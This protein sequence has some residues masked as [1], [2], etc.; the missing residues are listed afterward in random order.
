MFDHPGRSGRLE[1]LGP[2]LNPYRRQLGT[3]SEPDAARLVVEAKAVLPPSVRG[4]AERKR[5]QLER[6]PKGDLIR[7][8]TGVLQ[9]GQEGLREVAVP[10]EVEGVDA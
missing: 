6:N 10:R 3:R 1:E 4:E 9:P 2:G 8:L 7:E 5:P